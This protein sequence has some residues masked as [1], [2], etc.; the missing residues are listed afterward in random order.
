MRDWEHTLTVDASVDA[1]RRV[2]GIGIVVQ[3]RSED[4]G[5]GPIVA[6][7]AEAH[8]EIPF[9]SAEEFA[10]LRALEV[11]TERGFSRIKIRSDYN[12][13]RR[14]VRERH[15]RGTGR[16]DDE[17]RSKVLQLAGA[18]ERVDFGWVPRRKNQL[19]HALARQACQAQPLELHEARRSDD[20]VG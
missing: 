17:L 19:A 2:T 5:R 12:Q 16:V 20:V 9:G 7:I 10:V 11:A 14:A 13:M 3:K 1:K 4:R 15:R 18:F 6:R 8:A